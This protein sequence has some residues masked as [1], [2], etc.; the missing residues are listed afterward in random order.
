MSSS[1]KNLAESFS[2]PASSA[3]GPSALSS[4]SSTT[5][6]SCL[7]HHHY[8]TLSLREGINTFTGESTA[9]AAATADQ[10][11]LSSSP[12]RS[13]SL[14]YGGNGVEGVTGESANSSSIGF[15]GSS[16]PPIYRS[17]S[18][19]YDD[20]LATMSHHHHIYGTSSSHQPLTADGK[21]TAGDSAAQYSGSPMHLTLPPHHAHHPHHFAHHHH[22]QSATS[23]TAAAVAAAAAA[24]AAAAC[25]APLQSSYMPS[26]A[27]SS[28]LGTG[29][30]S[31]G[32]GHSSPYHHHAHHP[33]QTYSS[34]GDVAVATSCSTNSS[35][36]S[37]GSGSGGISGGGGD[38]GFADYSNHLPAY[39]LP[40]ANS[41][42]SV[43]YSPYHHHPHHSSYAH[44]Y[45]PSVTFG[46][47][48]MGGTAAHYTAAPLS[49]A[50]TSEVSTSPKGV[51]EQGE[52]Q[53]QHLL[54]QCSPGEH[55]RTP[56]TLTRLLA[57]PTLSP[58]SST[59]VP[60]V[61]AD[62]HALPD[63]ECSP[64]AV[65]NYS[66]GINSGGG[67]GSRQFAASAASN[68]YFYSN[69][70]PTY[71]L[72]S[73]GNIS[74]NTPTVTSS[75]ADHYAD[76]HS[77]ALYHHNHHHQY[78]RF[79][80]PTVP[81]SSTLQLDLPLKD[82][83]DDGKRGDDAAKEQEK[84]SLKRPL[85]GEESNTNKTSSVDSFKRHKMNGNNALKIIKQE[86]VD[87]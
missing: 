81:N 20:G 23:S 49:Q 82:A 62:D 27:Y 70:R 16:V 36:S 7:P 72:P 60:P 87:D 34:L 71:S 45:G 46:S 19:L 3:V 42:G 31:Y 40:S 86:E 24:A 77:A 68:P 44:S 76:Y 59:Q 74:S 73:G 32:Q 83:G 85:L 53:Q 30:G 61:I 13:S 17:G 12:P 75:A 80:A 63:N 38:P 1:G 43:H 57:L 55:L 22:H 18:A 65:A 2:S 6:T 9:A 35:S 8:E 78:G 37:V 41:T 39:L 51:D 52:Q 29:G 28:A 54:Q 50:T 64:P 67:G 21:Q 4:L 15:L 56:G 58:S 33:R 11:L 10:P 14:L 5:T 79:E 84:E 69:F 66:S 47:V 48:P 25:V 26:G